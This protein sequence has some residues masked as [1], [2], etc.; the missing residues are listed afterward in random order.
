M[1]NAGH[2]LDFILMR[3]GVVNTAGEAGGVV[4]SAG[5]DEASPVAAA[6]T[7]DGLDALPIRSRWPLVPPRRQLVPPGAAAFG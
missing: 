3:E 1:C 4:A 5:P 6:A 2:S 7:G